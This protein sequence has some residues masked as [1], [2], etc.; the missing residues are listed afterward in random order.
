[1]DLDTV[2]YVF[3]S[4]DGTFTIKPRLSRRWRVKHD[5]MPWGDSFATAE[6]AA[7]ALAARFAVPADLREWTEVGDFHT[8]VGGFTS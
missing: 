8:D 3:Q 1:M 2:S 7:K 6:E 4:L 5:S